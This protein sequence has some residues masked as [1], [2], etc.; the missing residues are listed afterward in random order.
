MWLLLIIFLL[1]LSIYVTIK[2]KFESYK[3]V[4][5]FKSIKKDKTS[6]YMSLGTKV[7]VGSIIGTTSS[8]IIG[9]Y[10]SVIWMIL[11]SIITSSLIYLEAYYGKNYREKYKDTYVSGSFYMLKNKLGKKT[12]SYIS[13][14]LLIVLYSFL[15]QM[16]Q[17]NTISN[18]ININLN[19]PKSIVIILFSLIILITLLFDISDVIKVMNK[20]VPIMCIIFIL[21][22]LYGIISNLSILINNIKTIQLFN[23][24]SI[25][26]GLIIGV[27]RSVF[28]NETLIGTTMIASGVD[29]N[30]IK[31]NAYIQV[32]GSYFIS[33]VITILI[34]LLLIIYGKTSSD[35]NTLISLVYYYTS[36][37]TG[38]YLIITTMILFAFTTLLS[39]YYIG[40]TN[41]E[42]IFKGKYTI[43]FKILF[44][45]SAISGAI[46]KNNYLWKYTDYLMYIMIL[47]N[48]YSII[49]LLG[50]EK[51]DRQWLGH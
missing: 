4:S 10:S 43:L 33:F 14:I 31:T 12:L 30:D 13:L 35:Y 42:A 26:I 27:K 47:I 15:F 24:T 3:F 40:F 34:A 18:I 19:I 32:L 50:S 37:Y 39:G 17:T 36:S 1:L 29:K 21:V 8:I 25:I 6:F 5:I 46:I 48:S 28:M 7:G 22:S 23:K 49:K 11:F 2:T 20:I 16:I 44:F 41:I 9:G 38:L 51:Y 45:I